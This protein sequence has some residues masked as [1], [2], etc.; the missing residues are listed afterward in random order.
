MERLGGRAPA[1]LRPSGFEGVIAVRGAALVSAE[2]MR[3]WLRD[4]DPGQG[5]TMAALDRAL[6]R[7]DRVMRFLDDC[8]RVCWHAANRKSDS[9]EAA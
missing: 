6:S 3:V 7:G 5:A 9:T 8:L 2:A 1:G 4:D